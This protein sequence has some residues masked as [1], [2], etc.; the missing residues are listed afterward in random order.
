MLDGSIEFYISFLDG[1]SKLK[2]KLADI[3]QE[4]GLTLAKK[5]N[6]KPALNVTK[7][8]ASIWNESLVLK[9][10]LDKKIHKGI[11][12]HLASCD[13]RLLHEIYEIK[14]TAPCF[15]YDML[16]TQ[17]Q[18]DSNDP[19]L[20]FNLNDFNYFCKELSHIF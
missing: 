4:Y 5:E 11:L 9:W 20:E 7:S 14:Q 2:L 12:T 13:G 15:L 3:Y 16:T 18:P 1:M 19:S 10:A 8:D 6:K 17:H